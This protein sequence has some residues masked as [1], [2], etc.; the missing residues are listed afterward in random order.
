MKTV[1]QED[2][3]MTEKEF[4]LKPQ[5]MYDTFFKEKKKEVF[6]ED[7]DEETKIYKVESE[8]G[9]QY[10]LRILDDGEYITLFRCDATDDELE[11]MTNYYQ[12]IQHIRHISKL[13]RGNKVEE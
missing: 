12:N 2:M 1:V 13:N 9:T 10:E 7:I 8:K 4:I 5:E 11:R 6:M 3:D